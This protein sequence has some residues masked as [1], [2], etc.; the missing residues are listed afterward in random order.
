MD[1]QGTK[2]WLKLLHGDPIETWNT[3]PNRLLTLVWFVWDRIRASQ[4]Y[5]PQS[6][7]RFSVLP[8]EMGRSVTRIDLVAAPH[9][10]LI[11]PCTT[12]KSRA[13]TTVLGKEKLSIF[14]KKG[15]GECNNIDECKGRCPEGTNNGLC[16]ATK[17][18]FEIFEVIWGQLRSFQII[19]RSDWT[20]NSSR[21]KTESINDARRRI[22]FPWRWKSFQ[23]FCQSVPTILYFWY[24]PRNWFLQHSRD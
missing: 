24:S 16:T 2:K 23:R 5:L 22:L 19:R 8:G 11:F 20:W 12:L 17:D 3:A 21:L 4:C 13:W 1:L 6:E 14:L 15:G 7:A 10:C 9:C 18:R